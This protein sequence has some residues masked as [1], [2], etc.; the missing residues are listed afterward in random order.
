MP[1][2]GEET[3]GDAGPDAGRFR[4]IRPHQRAPLNPL[5][6]ETSLHPLARRI[7]SLPY[8]RRAFQLPASILL[9]AFIRRA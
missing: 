2:E 1:R 6:A 8:L 4:R 9:P 3:C 7:P 5:G